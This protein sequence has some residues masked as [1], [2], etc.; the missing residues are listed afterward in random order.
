VLLVGLLL[1]FAVGVLL[2]M[3]LQHHLFEIV[4][5]YRQDV[6]G[7]P[8]IYAYN[9]PVA[10][11]VPSRAAQNNLKHKYDQG[12][13]PGVPKPFWGDKFDEL[14]PVLQ[15]AAGGMLAFLLFM[16]LLG[17]TGR[18]ATAATPAPVGGFPVVPQEP[19]GGQRKATFQKRR[20]RAGRR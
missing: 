3:T 17:P 6:A 5:V 16:G 19:R 13:E 12:T 18:R 20:S 7:R 8:Y 9:V 14:L 2:H 11:G 1:D 4:P 10:P 15:F